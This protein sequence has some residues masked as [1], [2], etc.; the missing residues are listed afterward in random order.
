MPP[1]AHA[2]AN[3]NSLPGFTLHRPPHPIR[4]P[5]SIDI[6][7]LWRTPLAIVA[8]LVI[9]LTGLVIVIV[10]E[11]LVL[12]FTNFPIFLGFGLLYEWTEIRLTM[13]YVLQLLHL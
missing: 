6:P 7:G 12:I 9:L 5:I 2:D 4:I 13:Y 3:S 1:I 10:R 8:P 11:T